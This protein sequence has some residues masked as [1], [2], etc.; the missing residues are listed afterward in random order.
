ME[1]WRTT[2]TNLLSKAPNRSYRANDVIT[3]ILSHLRP[4]YKRDQHPIFTKWRPA[5][6][7]HPIKFEA[8]IHCEAALASLAKYADRVSIKQTEGDVNL[9]GLLQVMF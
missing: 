8:T 2:V 7:E 3:F 6:H 1:S 5:I 9:L 4:P